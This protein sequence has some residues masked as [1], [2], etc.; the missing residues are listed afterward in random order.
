[1]NCVPDVGEKYRLYG[2]KGILFTSERVGGKYEI[3]A[4]AERDV[5][6]IR[7]SCTGTDEPCPDG[8]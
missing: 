7:V 1:M 4:G 8:I 3:Y 2:S 6:G 5:S